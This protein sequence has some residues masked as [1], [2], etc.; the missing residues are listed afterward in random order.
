MIITD[1]DGYPKRKIQATSV[2]IS[3]FSVY[4]ISKRILP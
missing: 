4:V 3:F 1:F 2:Q